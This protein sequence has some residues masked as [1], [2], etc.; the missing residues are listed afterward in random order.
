[1]I[2][3]KTRTESQVSRLALGTVQF[4]ADYGIANAQGKVSPE[5]VEKILN[6]AYDAG[7]N[8]LDTAI[9]YGESEK[10]LGNIGVKSWR[11]ISKL[12]TL[13]EMIHDT[14]GWVLQS[15]EDSLE[16]LKIPKLNGL[17]LHNPK[18]LLDARGGELYE[19]L[20]SLKTQGIVDKIGVSIYSPT[21]LEQLY[22]HFRFD[23][24]QSPFNLLDSR[25]AIS[26]WL[27]QLKQD[28]V[29]VHIRSVFL[30]GLLLMNSSN[31]PKYFN[32]WKNVWEQWDELIY[33]SNLS[34]LQICLGFV[35]SYPEFDRVLV[36]VDGLSQF[37]EILNSSKEYISEVPNSLHCN[38]TNL[39]N[40]S[41]WK[42]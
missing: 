29:E 9:A 11:V 28:Q 20:I 23:L 6:C 33:H 13:P 8:T 42:I 31:R 19:A 4:G 35:L 10:V 7:V 16:R 18:Q 34:P 27:S 26:G 5:E 1:M 21:E 14:I 25:L 41:C 39:I 40:P 24:V 12:P 3:V 32:R 22:P 38:D 2:E 15:V 17:L 36:G 37:L 30:Q